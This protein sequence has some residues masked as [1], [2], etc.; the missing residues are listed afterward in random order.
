MNRVFKM[1]GFCRVISILSIAASPVV[2]LG[3]TGTVRERIL[4][5]VVFVMMG[6][7]AS[8]VSEI[9]AFLEA[10]FGPRKN[11]TAR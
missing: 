4:M 3:S 5:A 6:L 2:Y 9:L 1:S 11:M 8:C 10:V 7:N